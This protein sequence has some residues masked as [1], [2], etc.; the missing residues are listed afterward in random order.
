M[1]SSGYCPVNV[2]GPELRELLKTAELSQTKFAEIIG[3]APNTVSRWSL[4]LL[5]VPR[6]AVAYLQLRIKLQKIFT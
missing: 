5:P 2:T 1:E 3:V 4:D 6:Y